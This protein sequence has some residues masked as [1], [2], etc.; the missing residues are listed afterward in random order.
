MVPAQPLMVLLAEVLAFFGQILFYRH[1]AIPSE[2]RCYCGV[3]T[4]ADLTTQVFH[5]HGLVAM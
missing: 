2:F 5:P 1:C 3:P 4:Y